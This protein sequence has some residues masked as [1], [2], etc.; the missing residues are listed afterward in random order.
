MAISKAVIAPVSPLA[1]VSE[2]IKAMLSPVN[3][4]V[5]DIVERTAAPVEVDKNIMIGPN[6]I[7]PA[8]IGSSG[9]RNPLI[10]RVNSAQI[11]LRLSINPYCSLAAVAY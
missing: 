3:A 7:I 4:I 10:F 1:A 5:W 2:A 11:C 9:C 6:A 8:K